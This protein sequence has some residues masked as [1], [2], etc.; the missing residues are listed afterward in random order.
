MQTFLRLEFN[1]LIARPFFVLSSVLSPLPVEGVKKKP[2]QITKR[3]D[4]E[5]SYTYKMISSIQNVSSLISVML[6]FR[7]RLLGILYFTSNTEIY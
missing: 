6:K 3:K 1:G 4:G 2:N 5:V 7:V